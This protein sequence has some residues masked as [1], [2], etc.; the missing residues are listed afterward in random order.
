MAAPV[1][2]PPYAEIREKLKKRRS[3]GAVGPKRRERERER[4]REAR[5]ERER[6]GEREGGRMSEMEEAK[7][8]PHHPLFNV[9]THHHP[10]PAAQQDHE[11]HPAR[12]GVLQPKAVS[13]KRMSKNR[14]HGCRA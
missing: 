13:M 11:R 6:E 1:R 5:R 3:N 9:E 10:L 7:H 8:R 14:R 4:G 2:K 12:R